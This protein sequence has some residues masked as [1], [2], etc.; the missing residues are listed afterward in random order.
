MSDSKSSIVPLNGS[1]FATWKVQC[2]MALMRD[3]L[4]GYVDGTEV[5][6]DRSDDR[7]M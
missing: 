4:W 3:D 1:N 2:R 5:V 7:N 6:P